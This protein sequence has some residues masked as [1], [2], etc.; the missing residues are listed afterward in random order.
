MNMSTTPLPTTRLGKWSA[1]LNIV[2]VLIIVISLILVLGLHILSFGDKWWDATVP[3]AFLIEMIAFIT[4]IRAI[5]K[6]KDH[7]ALVIL[8]IVIGVCTILF[9]PLHSLFISD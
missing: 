9:I 6:Y 2:F 4:G 1:G 8:S 5:K 7:S 3:I